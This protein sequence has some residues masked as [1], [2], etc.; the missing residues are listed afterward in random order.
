MMQKL[1]RNPSETDSIKSQISFKT[2]VGKRKAQK[3]TNEDITSDSQVN[4]NFPY[5][6]SPANL[7][8]NVYFTDILYLYITN[9]V[10]FRENNVDKTVNR[11]QMAPRNHSYRVYIV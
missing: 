1:V 7:T 5:R 6:W 11:G 2:S 4:S 8:F 9:L 3:D 10:I